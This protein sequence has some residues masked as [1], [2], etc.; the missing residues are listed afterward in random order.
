MNGYSYTLEKDDYLQLLL[1]Q[2]EVHDGKKSVIL[3]S[4]AGPLVFSILFMLHLRERG[5]CTFS[6]VLLAFTFVLWFMFLSKGKTRRARARSILSRL[7]DKKAFDESF[8]SRHTLKTDGSDLYDS[9]GHYE[10]S[11][12]IS[13]LLPPVYF[14]NIIIL[15]MAEGSFA[16]MKKSDEACLFLSSIF[17]LPI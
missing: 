10:R 12:P 4:I 2:L 1:W 17:H 6:V 8:F 9:Y 14:S 7:V 15:P 3:R 13:L 11:V 5:W 16:V